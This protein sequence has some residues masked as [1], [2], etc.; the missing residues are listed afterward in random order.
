MGTKKKPNNKEITKAIIIPNYYHSFCFSCY[1]RFLILF[2]RWV[3][4]FFLVSRQIL[5]LSLSNDSWLRS[6]GLLI[7]WL[8]LINCDNLHS[9]N[10]NIF[11]N[12][13][14]I[15][16]SM[17]GHVSSLWGILEYNSSYQWKKL[18]NCLLSL[19]SSSMKLW[20]PK[21]V[22]ALVELELVYQHYPAK[23]IIRFCSLMGLGL[24][25]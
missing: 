13:F 6:S 2:L 8:I 23:N 3:R 21:L 10:A 20:W 7:F 14:C 25:I 17:E 5:D 11:F 19:S 16:E 24:Q 12:V 1:C 9:E 18:W 4:Y 15:A 22:Y